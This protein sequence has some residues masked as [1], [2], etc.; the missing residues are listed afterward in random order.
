LNVSAPHDVR[1]LR[2][3]VSPEEW[4]ARVDLAACSRLV[5]RYGWEDL[6]A[7]CAIQVRAQAGGGELI[8]V[9]KEI[10][11][12]AYVQLAA[13]ARPRVSRGMLVWPG[14]LWRLD[15]ADPSYRT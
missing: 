6:E 3:T 7:S 14:L 4:T 2:D 1:S 9:P 5:A 11:A 12:T 13:A 15:R 8:S 10:I